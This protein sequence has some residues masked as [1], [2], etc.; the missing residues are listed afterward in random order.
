MSGK[1]IIGILLIVLGTA[2]LVLNGWLFLLTYETRAAL[3]TLMSGL[4][5]FAG[6]RY[7]RQATAEKQSK[8][9]NQ[10]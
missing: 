9:K 2:S 8:P 5:I 3:F 7:Y 1:Q 10:A 4:F 6:W